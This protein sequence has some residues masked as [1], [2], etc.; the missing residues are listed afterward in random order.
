[1]AT[2]IGGKYLLDAV[3]PRQWSKFASE[4]RLPPA[5]ILDMGR[6]MVETVPTAFAAIVEVAR[7]QGLDH[8]ILQR[9]LQVL[10]ARSEHCSS[11]LATSTN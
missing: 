9:M 3:Y 10:K 7:T 5:E 8:P 6:S 1:M 11:V 2:K 4:V